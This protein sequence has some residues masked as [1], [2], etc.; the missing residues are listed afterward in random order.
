[1][2]NTMVVFNRQ[3]QVNDIFTVVRYDTITHEQSTEYLTYPRT[4]NMTEDDVREELED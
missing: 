1:M 2:I 3:N 4:M